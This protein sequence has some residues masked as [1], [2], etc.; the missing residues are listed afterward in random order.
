MHIHSLC[1][2]VC[3]P[4][5]V[6]LSVS[7]CLSVS[8]SLSHSHTHT[9]TH[10]RTHTEERLSWL[11]SLVGSLCSREMEGECLHTFS[12][13]VLFEQVIKLH[14]L[15]VAILL[16]SCRN[17]NFSWPNWLKRL[18]N[19]LGVD[20]IGLYPSTQEAEAGGTLSMRPA[21]STEGVLGQPRPHRETLSQRNPTNQTSK[22]YSAQCNELRELWYTQW[23]YTSV[24]YSC[25]FDSSS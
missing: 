25:S 17:K 8:L 14:R 7:V 4:L 12:Y 21:W 15:H 3:L 18:T 10:T 16:L 23:L 11:R 9:H 2:S 22:T 24:Q 1:V 5:S 19:K 6:S 13:T 20:G